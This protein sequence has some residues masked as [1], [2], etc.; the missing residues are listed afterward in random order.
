MARY[1]DAVTPKEIKALRKQLKCTPREL[2]EALGVPAADII[3][4]EQDEKFPT[5]RF[6]K[7]MAQLA[8][9][10]P[11]AVPRLR[12]Q[13]S[14]TRPERVLADPEIWRLIRKLIAH[15]ELRA[16]ALALARAYADPVA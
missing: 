2:G 12:T 15:P 7:A 11:G 16:K 1:V 5:K 13:R 3:A 6:I 10:G 4:W 8:E 9:E 14:E